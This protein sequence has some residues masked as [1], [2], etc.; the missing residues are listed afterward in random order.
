M[1]VDENFLNN[2]RKQ[3]DAMLKATDFYIQTSDFP[4]ADGERQAWIDYRQAL[5][6]ITTL[7]E[8]EFGTENLFWPNPPKRYVLNDG[9]SIN[10][11]SDYT[12]QY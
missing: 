1:A 8:E 9:G 11:P 4:M 7:T 3:R 10:L 12:D 5:R 2:V 6:D